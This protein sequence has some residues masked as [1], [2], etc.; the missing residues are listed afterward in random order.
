MELP[1]ISIA[2]KDS[3][4]LGCLQGAS[5]LLCL[6]ALASIGGRKKKIYPAGYALQ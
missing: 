1:C 6:A 2:L 4:S 3:S 5:L